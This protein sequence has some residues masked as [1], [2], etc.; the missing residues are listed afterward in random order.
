MF[1]QS[2]LNSE[3]FLCL[4]L[5]CRCFLQVSCCVEFRKLCFVNG[6]VLLNERVKCQ[7]LKTLSQAS[8]SPHVYGETSSKH[9]PEHSARQV[10]AIS[11]LSSP[12]ARPASTVYIYIYI[13]ICVSLILFVC[14]HPCTFKCST[15]LISVQ[16]VQ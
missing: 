15:R 7:K 3:I 9:L 12:T 4:C 8:F 13:Y 16:T 14:L 10:S 6:V 2:S 5:S 11:H 1:C